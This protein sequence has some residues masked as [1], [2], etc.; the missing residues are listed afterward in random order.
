[1]MPIL[2]PGIILARRAAW[3]CSGGA[4]HPDAAGR[5][6]GLGSQ[7][8]VARDFLQELL[9][10]R[11]AV[12]SPHA[13]C[14]KPPDTADDVVHAER[15]LHPPSESLCRR[16]NFVDLSAGQ[17]PVLLADGVP[18]VVGAPGVACSFA[19]LTVPAGPPPTRPIL[20]SCAPG[21]Q[22]FVR[23]GACGWF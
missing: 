9:K 10:S 1:M 21:C 3:S 23:C 12:R 18:R 8:A 22:E 16:R 5:S 4:A 13:C 7:I 11:L 6:R 17:P 15:P 19:A 2:T 14:A 20:S